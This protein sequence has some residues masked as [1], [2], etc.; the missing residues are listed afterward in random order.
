M[1]LHKPPTLADKGL[2]IEKAYI[3]GRWQNSQSCR[4]FQ[5]FDPATN[6]I[7]GECPECSVADLERA[8]SAAST[9]LDLWR[10][11]SGRERSLILRQW[12]ELILENKDDIATLIV[13]ENGKSYADAAGEVLFAASF[14]DWY[15][16]E[17]ARIYG[18]IIPH[19]NRDISVHV[20]KEPIG[21][22]ALITP[23]NYPAAMVTRKAAPALAA[24]CT[25]IIKTDGLTPYTANAI[26]KLGERAGI[27]SGVVNVVTALEDTPRIGLAICKSEAIR[28]VSFTGST[29][30]GKILAEN[31][32]STLKKLSLELGG[33][34]PFI[35]YD[36]ANM[37]TAIACCLKSKFKSSGQTCVCANRIYV[38]DAIFDA[39]VSRLAG[40]IANLQLGSGFNKQVD[41]GPLISPQA[42]AKVEEH[43]H[44]AVSKGARVVVGGTRSH[45]GPQ[46]FEPTLLAGLDDDMKVASE[47]TFGPLAGIFRFST[48]IEV[49]RRANNT[50]VGLAAYIMT[51]DLGRAQRT[52]E[53]LR[54]GMVA[55][56]TAIISDAPVPFG[57]VRDSGLGREGGKYGL[58]EYLELKAVM[59]AKI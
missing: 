36:D 35:V 14:L 6:E 11:Y 50:K 12:Y 10:L 34:A 31:S 2:F 24:G 43:I 42:V 33:N 56:N 19:S 20:S 23:W 17:A 4:T 26:V 57:G 16:E 25:I 21:V 7:I 39:F 59:T 15:S 1:S 27:P 46:F 58:E 52:S 13:W 41:I 53:Q 5:V 37:D 40:E 47:E 38:Q 49:I 55:I 44:D 8:V 51:N 9:A 48:E 18:D 32:G 30:V 54:T 22:C 28:K 3:A 29:R 45:L